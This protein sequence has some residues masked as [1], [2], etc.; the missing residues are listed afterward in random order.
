MRGVRITALREL[1]SDY[2][3]AIYQSELIFTVRMLMVKQLTF[4]L[5]QVS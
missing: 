1:T 2:G 5:C 3:C 4:D